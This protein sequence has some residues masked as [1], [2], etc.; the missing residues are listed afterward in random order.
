MHLGDTSNEI[1]LYESWHCWMHFRIIIPLKSSYERKTTVNRSAWSLNSI[2]NF[3]ELKIIFRDNFQCIKV[4]PV[5][6]KV[7]Y[8]EATSAN[9]QL[10][11]PHSCSLV[12]QHQVKSE[13]LICVKKKVVEGCKLGYTRRGLGRVWDFN[14]KLNHIVLISQAPSWWQQNGSIHKTFSLLLNPKQRFILLLN[15]INI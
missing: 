6:Q 5:R 12:S 4:S 13:K 3:I 1:K 9:S 11:H 2:K 7:L 10:V 14:L 8:D 15:Y